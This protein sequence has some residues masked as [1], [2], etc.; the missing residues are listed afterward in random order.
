MSLKRRAFVESRDSQK[1]QDRRIGDRCH[2]V[3]SIVTTLFFHRTA[4]HDTRRDYN[5]DSHTYTQLRDLLNVSRSTPP[6]GVTETPCPWEFHGA[7]VFAQFRVGRFLFFSPSGI[8]LCT[9]A[10]SCIYFSHN[11]RRVSRSERNA[12][13]MLRIYNKEQCKK[14]RYIVAVVWPAQVM[15]SVIQT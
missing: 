5:R 2:A 13:L 12:F 7:A 15:G 4:W 9:C 3:I 1:E 6:I 10:Q 8:D 14:L 11:D